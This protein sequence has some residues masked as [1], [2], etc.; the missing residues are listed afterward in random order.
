MGDKLSYTIA[1]ASQLTA[2]SPAQLRRWCQEGRIGFKFGDRVWVIPHED[3]VRLTGE[4]MDA[5][6]EES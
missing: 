1:E 5:W 2:F 3:L 6:K 4:L